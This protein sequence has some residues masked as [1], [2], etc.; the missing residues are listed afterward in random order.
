MA[1]QLNNTFVT[2]NERHITKP[3]M[4]YDELLT[5]P[6][7]ETK[8]QVILLRD[9]HRCRNCGSEKRLQVHHR[10]YHVNKYGE[11]VK[12]WNYSNRYLITLC[13]ECHKIGH[14]QFKI[15]VFK[16]SY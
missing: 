12:P 8:R 5:T 4:T 2:E 1:A 16:I 7:W 9:G 13:D 14:G 11:K 15:P 3:A 10:Q 6:Q